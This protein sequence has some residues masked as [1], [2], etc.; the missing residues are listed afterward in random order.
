MRAGGKQVALAV[1]GR[2]RQQRWDRALALLGMVQRSRLDVNLECRSARSGAGQA[3]GQ[4]VRSLRLTAAATKQASAAFSPAK[5]AACVFISKSTKA[6]HWRDAIAFFDQLPGKDLNVFVAS[7]AVKACEVGHRWRHALC[8]FHRSLSSGVD[9]DMIMYSGLIS[10][11]EKGEQWD[12]ALA[13]LLE[14]QVVH[15]LAPNVV[16]FSA[17]ISACEKA[18]R[19][20]EALCLFRDVRERLLTPDKVMYGAVISACE[21]GHQWLRALSFLRRM[22]VALVRPDAAL[23][24]AAASACERVGQWRTAAALLGSMRARRLGPDLRQLQV[25]AQQ[26]SQWESSLQLLWDL[27]AAAQTDM[28]SFTVAATACSTFRHW[29]LAVG[30]LNGMS[31]LR[32]EPN[33][34]MCGAV[35]AACEASGQREHFQAACAQLQKASLNEFIQPTCSVVDIGSA[36]HFGNALMEH[37]ILCSV[38][39]RGCTK[40]TFSASGQGSHSVGELF[41]GAVRAG[42]EMWGQLPSWSQPRP[43]ARARSCSARS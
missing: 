15:E 3:S 23:W 2:Q 13:L 29:R 31:T 26:G 38:F 34:V 24:I 18:R 14:M 35:A 4:S 41:A 20:P 22:Q 1:V 37:R 28:L 10:A 27:H 11:C 40:A 39:L 43:S 5:V 42:L 16:A 33:V 36:V 8:V 25:R 19:W 32:V 12:I 21:K 7:A 9:P 6:R 17:A 30:L